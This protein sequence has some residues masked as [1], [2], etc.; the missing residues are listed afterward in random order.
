MTVPALLLNSLSIVGL[1]SSTYLIQ[2]TIVFLVHY[3][4]HKKFPSSINEDKIELLKAEIRTLR[5]TISR[6]EE[7]NNEIT[8]AVIKR[9]Q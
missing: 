5:T 2:Q 7:E 3:A 6:L 8:K 9:L 4:K 1:I